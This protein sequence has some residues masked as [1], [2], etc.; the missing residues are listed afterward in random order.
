LP[1]VPGSCE[2]PRGLGGRGFRFAAAFRALSRARRPAAACLRLAA[3]FAVAA[4]R[5]RRRSAVAA[6][7]FRA[8]KSVRTVQA[9]R[10]PRGF[11]HV[12]H[13]H[14]TGACSRVRALRRPVA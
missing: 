12:P 10:T 13:V 5:L 4:F 11:P 7:R 6:F 8:L 2:S 3:R 9:C 1:Q 14:V